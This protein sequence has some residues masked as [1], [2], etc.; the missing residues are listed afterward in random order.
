MTANTNWYMT[1]SMCFKYIT[2]DYKLQDKYVT[3]LQD[4]RGEGDWP[5]GGGWIYMECHSHWFMGKVSIFFCDWPNTIFFGS[6]S[7]RHTER[8]A[9]GGLNPPTTLVHLRRLSK[10]SKARINQ[11]F[12]KLTSDLIFRSR[13]GE[14][15]QQVREIRLG[16]GL[17]LAKYYNCQL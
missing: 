15:T 11:I 14:C 10:L 2:F 8:L 6:P 7:R 12:V 13:L 9:G 5:N 16:K 1:G 4:R 3:F 17:G